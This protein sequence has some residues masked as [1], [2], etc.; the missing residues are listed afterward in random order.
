MP[1]LLMSISEPVRAFWP[2]SAFQTPS[3]HQTEEMTKTR[4]LIDAK[5]TL[6]FAVDS[7]HKSARTERSW[8]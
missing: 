7:A 2:S 1:Q 3:W 8:K 5:V 6:S 4:Q